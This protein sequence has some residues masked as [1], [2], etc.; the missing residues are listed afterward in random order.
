[1]ALIG[2]VLQNLVSNAIKYG[3]P[4]G[5]IA[6]SVRRKGEQWRIDV[7]NASHGIAP[8]HR[9]RLF[10][11]FYRADHAHQRRVDGVGLGLSL[12][13]DIAVAHG[14]SLVLADAEPGQVRFRL[15]L[16]VA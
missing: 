1:M 14:G 16:P 12:A 3:L 7:A 11:R 4:G 8:E 2:T 10:D 13:R 15:S 5:W 9:H 6:L